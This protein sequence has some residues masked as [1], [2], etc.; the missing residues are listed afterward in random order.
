MNRIST[1]WMTLAMSFQKTRQPTLVLHHP[2][3]TLRRPWMVHNEGSKP[4]SIRPLVRIRRIRILSNSLILK[5][6]L[7]PATLPAFA[8]RP[9]IP[10]TTSW[11]FLWRT[12]KTM[13]HL[14]LIL[15][16]TI[17]S[18]RRHSRESTRRTDQRL[19]GSNRSRKQHFLLNHR[20][21]VAFR[22][23][24]RVSSLSLTPHPFR[25]NRQPQRRLIRSVPGVPDA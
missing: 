16:P 15:P 8:I 14:Q 2:V 24:S 18:C 10:F 25:R 9:S 13:N 17:R 11:A 3:K 19:G 12:R 22:L 4:P 21:I 1:R 23:S 6:I 20:P 7:P 5:R